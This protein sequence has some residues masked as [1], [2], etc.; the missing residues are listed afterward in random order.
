MPWN[1]FITA[2]GY[3]IDYKLKGPCGQPESEYRKFFMNY[4]GI[5]AQLPNVLLNVTNLF[6]HL[7]GNIKSRIVWSIVTMIIIFVFTIIMAMVDSSQWIEAFFW[8]TM[9]SVVILN[10]ATGVYQNSLYGLV[11]ILPPRYTNAVILGNNISGTITTTVSV[12]SKLCVS[13]LEGGG[14]D[15]DS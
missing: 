10:A 9:V 6:V 4:L 1:M 2:H 5:V 12:I 7:G 11:A 15:P 14:D 3:F 8:L 13:S